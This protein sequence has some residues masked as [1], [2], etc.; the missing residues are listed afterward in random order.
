VFLVLVVVFSQ[1]FPK[2]KRLKIRPHEMV[3]VIWFSTLV[4]GSSWLGSSGR[5]KSVFAKSP[6]MKIDL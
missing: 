3:V 1:H 4:V 2:T 6:F 5:Q